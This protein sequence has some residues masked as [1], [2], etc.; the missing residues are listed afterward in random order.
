ML[1]VP[2]AAVYPE[3]RAMK[4][5]A[6][7]GALERLAQYFWCTT[8]MANFDQGA[9]SQA[10]ADHAL[11]KNWLQG[12]GL[13]APEAVA[14]FNL[15]DSAL[16]GATIRRK[17]LHAGVMALTI[18]SGAKDFHSGRKLTAPKLV[19][20]KIDSHHIFPK[21]YLANSNSKF[22]PELILNRALIDSDT[23]KVIGKKAPSVYLSAMRDAHGRRSLRTYWTRI[24][25]NVASILASK[26]T[27][28]TS[29]FRS[30]ST[31]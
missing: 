3:L 6:R 30:D 21:A 13:V 14:N 8:F 19:E 10:G 7:A 28:T 18:R 24:R 22:S 1:L 25:S 5:L 29:F 27:T 23:N 15:R 16:L 20:R 17:A 12:E 26:T 4:G 31:R 2:M 11:L 9:N